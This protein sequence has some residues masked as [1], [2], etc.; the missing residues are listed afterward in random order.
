MDTLLGLT[1]YVGVAFLLL[2]YFLLTIGQMKATDTHHIAL[3]ALGA[4]FVVIAMR[5]GSPAPLFI[6]LVLWLCIS[7]F[8]FYKRHIT[9]TE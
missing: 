1:G 9:T 4:L 5:T 8:G 3:N 7:L 6:T 2:A